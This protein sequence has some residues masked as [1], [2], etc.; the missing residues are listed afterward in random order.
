[1]TV[2]QLGNSSE[3]SMASDAE[4]P[5]QAILSQRSCSRHRCRPRRRRSRRLSSSSSL[6]NCSCGCNSAYMDPRKMKAAATVDGLRQGV[7]ALSKAKQMEQSRFAKFQP[8]LAALIKECEQGDGGCNQS[9]MSN[10]LQKKIKAHE[11]RELGCGCTK[12]RLDA[13]A[14]AID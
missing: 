2:A 12:C 4:D 3:Q 6:S 14:K 5:S 9:Q 7:L 10:C 1:M 13:A 11:S 8:K